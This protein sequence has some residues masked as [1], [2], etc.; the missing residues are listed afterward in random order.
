MVFDARYCEEQTDRFVDSLALF[1]IGYSW[2]G[3]HSLVL[4]YRM[5]AMRGNWGGQGTLVRFN[6]G[7]EDT[8][9]LIADI[10][11]ALSQL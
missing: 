11:N 7:L 9:D 10:Q 5:A 4:P 1:G 3:A 2:G 8:A 6:I